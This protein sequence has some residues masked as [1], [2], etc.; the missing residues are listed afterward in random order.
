MGVEIER[1]FLVIS[2]AWRESA[3]EGQRLRQGYLAAS[4]LNSVRIRIVDEAKAK[5][6]V[7][8]ALR[9][10]T[11]DEF[12]YDVPVPDAQAMLSLCTGNIIDKTRHRISIE[13]LVWEVD[14]FARPNAGLIVAEVELDSEDQWFELPRWVGRE[15][16]AD[17]RYQNSK[18]AITPSSEWEDD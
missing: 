2:D 14:V 3:P 9:G 6:S 18:L 15:V 12:E 7:K 17:L 5:L 8:S 4:D 11:R 13:G 16:T 1:K 10:M